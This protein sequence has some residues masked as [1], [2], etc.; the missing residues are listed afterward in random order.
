MKAVT[1]LGITACLCLA[2][3]AQTTRPAWDEV[4]VLAELRALPRLARTHYTWPMPA[5]RLRPGDPLLGEYA[6]VAGGVGI[7]GEW[8]SR[9]EAD[10]AFFACRETGARIAINYSPWHRKF[11]AT[12]PP[13]TTGPSE[14]AELAMMRERL[15]AKRAWLD[16]F[17][18]R[19]AA[20]VA[21]GVILLDAERFTTKTG[22]AAWNEALDRKYNL[23]FSVAKAAFPSTPVLYCAQGCRFASY[24][25]GR[26]WTDR[27]WND[28]LYY[29]GSPATQRW[30]LE[31]LV[32]TADE[33]GGGQVCAWLSLAAG[34]VTPSAWT[35]PWDYDPAADREL[36]AWLAGQVR[37]DFVIFYPAPFASPAWAEKFVAYARGA[38][39]MQG[40]S[41]PRV[42]PADFDGD[43]D[44]DLNDWT[45]FQSCYSGPN[46]PP[47]C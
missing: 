40:T 28:T 39:G 3:Q 19:Y 27:L 7:S 32:K 37:L 8:T 41:A 30:R 16:D 13:T 29:P 17:N 22:D 14:E 45:V 12:A 43:G 1:A 2:A 42:S 23:T 25:T 44:V 15:A 20:K 46:V 10:A 47:R 5:A 18:A 6:R 24:F 33:R 35:D 31:Q 4:R 26:E 34:Y 9:I 38:A 21:V 11:L 36:G